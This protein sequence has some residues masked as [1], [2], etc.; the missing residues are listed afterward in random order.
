MS[1]QIDV[2]YQNGEVVDFCCMGTEETA[3]ITLQQYAANSME[4]RF[5]RING[6]CEEILKMEDFSH[7]QVLL[8]YRDRLLA[9]TEE[10][11]FFE[12]DTQHYQHLKITCF[13]INTP[14][15]QSVLRSSRWDIEPVRRGKIAGE[16]SIAI[17]SHKMEYALQL[18]ITVPITVCAAF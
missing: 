3:Q 11:I 4:F 13:D 16:L 8:S 10:N 7:A 1:N 9:A 12:E 14:E 15:T 5:C 2:I 17:Y 18:F 6:V